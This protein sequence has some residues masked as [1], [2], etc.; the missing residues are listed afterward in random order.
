[1]Y[2]DALFFL[3]PT[4]T[5]HTHTHT[6]TRLV[7]TFADIGFGACSGYIGPGG[8]LGDFGAH[9]GCTGGNA[10]ALDKWFFG[11]DHLYQ[12]PTPGESYLV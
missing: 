4:Y 11:A 1:V 9:V 7:L 6:C 8:V 3:S 2:I 5:I 10:G 12:T